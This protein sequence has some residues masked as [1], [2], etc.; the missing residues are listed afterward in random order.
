[1]LA[2]GVELLGRHRHPVELLGG[3]SGRVGKLVGAGLGR[4]LAQQVTELAWQVLYTF[5][6]AEH[7]QRGKVVGQL[8]GLDQLRAVFVEHHQCPGGE[9][10]DLFDFYITLRGIERVGQL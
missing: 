3:Q 7:R 1:M 8:V 10:G 4:R 6:H 2:F 5:L 9:G